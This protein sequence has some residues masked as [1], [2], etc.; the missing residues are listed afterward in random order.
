MIEAVGHEF[1]PTYFQKCASLLREGGEMVIQAITIP[2]QRYERYRRSVDFIQ[3]YI[4][5]GGCLPSLG[6]ISPAVATTHD[7]RLVHMEDFSGALRRH[8]G[9]LAESLLGTNRSCAPAGVR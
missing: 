4:F 9:R 1:L 5:P 2:D 3:R 6:A 7:L 8:A